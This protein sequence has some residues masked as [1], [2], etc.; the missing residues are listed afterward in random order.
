[1]KNPFE[2]ESKQKHEEQNMTED[3]KLNKNSKNTN[4]KSH[5]NDWNSNVDNEKIHKIINV[6]EIIEKFKWQIVIALAIFTNAELLIIPVIFIE[7]IIK[8][9]KEKFDIND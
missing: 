2:V 8:L 1:M 4:K 6:L 5:N 9:I 3:A 7:S